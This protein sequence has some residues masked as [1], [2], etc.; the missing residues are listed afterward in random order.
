M[1]EKEGA[2]FG[3]LG[4]FGCRMPRQV[5]RVR[6]VDWFIMSFFNFTAE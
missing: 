5:L 4:S 6:A 1:I 2:G 3:L